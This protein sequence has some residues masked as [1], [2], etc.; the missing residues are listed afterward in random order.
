MLYIKK[1]FLI[2][3]KPTY[4][5]AKF[6]ISNFKKGDYKIE[7]YNIIGKKLWSTKLVLSKKTMVKYDFSFLRKG[8]YLITLKD[9]FGKVIRT[10][11]LMII[12]I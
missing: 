11:K 10:R 5:T 3:P 4:N 2:Y 8:T 7:I 1:V 12:S 6:L 9:R